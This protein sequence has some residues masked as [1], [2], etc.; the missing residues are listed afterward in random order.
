M[1]TTYRYRIYPNKKQRIQ[2]AKTFG[3]TRFV[4][5]YFLSW[6]E[7]RYK[8]QK[9]STTESECRKHL[10][11]ILKQQYPWLREVDKFALENALI[12]LDNAYK[13]FF[14]HQ[15]G[16]PHFKTKK[17]HR[18]SYTTYFTGNNIEIDFGILAAQSNKNRCWGK[19]KLPK[20]GWVKARIHRTF[21]G[22]IKTATVKMLPSGEYYVC[23]SVEHNESVYQNTN[24]V[25]ANFVVALDLGIKDFY[26]DSNGTCVKAPKVLFKYERR[27][28]KLQRNLSRKVVGSKSFAKARVRLAKL[29]QRISNIRKDFIEKQSSKVINENQ[30]IICED[31]RIKNMVQN[32]RLAK[33]ILDV[34][35]SQFI[36]MLGYKAKRHNR[37]FVQLSPNF[38]S[39]QLCSKCGYKNEAVRDL[40]V[41]IWQC[42]NC[43]VL[44][45]RDHNAAKN[46]LKHGLMQ[47]GISAD[48][49]SKRVGL[50]R[51]EPNGNA[52]GDWVS[53]AE[54]SKLIFSA[55]NSVDEAGS[56]RL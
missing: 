7:Q 13:R 40:S 29:Y 30:V 42:P 26:V 56:P 2:L 43:G 38:P 55:A 54:K 44:H 45:N 46:L 8:E 5:N 19:I 11:N 9:L 4:W 48:H 16:K 36:S 47:L 50:G 35:W 32:N 20:L 31:L 27:L 34:S 15:G 21:V 18:F 49:M 1:I 17:A 37:V 23:L 24:T 12:N 28:K 53:T 25:P 3:C 14:R 22:R 52:C 51:S 39:S 41:R 10:N 6:R 33:S